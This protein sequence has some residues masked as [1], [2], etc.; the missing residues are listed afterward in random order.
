MSNITRNPKG[1]GMVRRRSD[2]RWEGRYTASFDPGTG[3]QIQRSVYGKTKAEV[4]QKLHEITFRLDEGTYLE[5][6]R[7]TIEEWI[8][9]WL[10]SYLNN[11]KPRTLEI[12]KDNSRRYIIPYLGKVRLDALTTPMIQNM[13]NSL[14]REKKLAPKTI[15]AIHGLFH[16]ALKQAMAVGKLRANPADACVLPRVQKKELT[17][18]DKNDI[19]A[20][21]CQIKGSPYEN[22]FIVTLFTG[23]RESEVLGLQWHCVDFI[24]GT[25]T[26]KQQLLRSE[27]RNG[28]KGQFYL[29][30]P[31]NGKSR[32][33]TPAPFVMDVL[34]DQKRQQEEMKKQAGS[35]WND[36]GWVFSTADGSHE[37]VW[38]IYRHYKNAVTAIGRPDARFH[39]LRHSYAAS[40]IQAGDDIKTLQENLGHATAAFTLDVYGHVTDQMKRESANRMQIFIQNLPTSATG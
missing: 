21:L 39:D 33:I 10:E 9:I 16:K 27:A 4:T 13:Y 30:V 11:V 38:N 15:K 28:E 2:G 1:S 8:G 19:A 5:P 23:M 40:S 24:Y 17:P 22:L 35:A 36:E 26:V 12:Y 20:F 37:A 32:T 3:K 29:G 6:C 34:R 25:I 31:K 7:M 18:L 14:L